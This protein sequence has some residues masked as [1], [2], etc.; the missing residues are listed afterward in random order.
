MVFLL[1]AL[2]KEQVSL[3]L[4]PKII[5]A[6]DGFGAQA[7]NSQEL[8][9]SIRKYLGK[10]IGLSLWN[11]KDVLEVITVDAM[12]EQ[13]VRDSQEKVRLDLHEK[14]VSQVKNLLRESEGHFR[15]I[16]TGAETRKELKR[17]VDP[18]FPDLLVLAHSE[19]PEEM[20]ITL[21]G[22]VSDEVL[23]S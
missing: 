3:H 8:V 4:F 18:Y 7:Q 21:L 2:V 19:L 16:V 1:R 9:E 6:I 23:L 12:V 5:E 15:A 11:R 13:F 10:H 20:P 17:I 14:V 22:A